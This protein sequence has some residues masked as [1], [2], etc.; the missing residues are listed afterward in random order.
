MDSARGSLASFCGL[1]ASSKSFFPEEKMG[2]G[3]KQETSRREA[4]YA[5]G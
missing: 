2:R 1:R 4:E 3:G 5:V